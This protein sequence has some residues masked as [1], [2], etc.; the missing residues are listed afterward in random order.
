MRWDELGRADCSIAQTLSVIG[1]RWTLLIIRDCFRGLRKFD[2]FLGSL[3]V[4]RTILTDRLA[5]LVDEGVLEKAPYQERPT[6]YD[7]RLTQKGQDLYPVILTLVQ[8]GDQYRKDD[9]LPPIK[10]KHKSCGHFL[11]PKV[12]CEECGE[13]VKPKQVVDVRQPH[14]EAS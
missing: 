8:W 7:Y 5:K 12:I 11:K 13:E 14:K 4:S 10:L 2:D 1:D 6:R 9:K 3:N